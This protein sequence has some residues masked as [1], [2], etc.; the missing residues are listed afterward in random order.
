MNSKALF[1]GALLAAGVTA[2][3]QQFI[4]QDSSSD[5]AYTSFAYLVDIDSN[6]YNIAYA[7]ESLNTSL[8]GSYAEYS[9]TQSS[10]LLRIDAQ[11]DGTSPSG[12]AYGGGAF[13]QYFRV[14]EDSDLV[15]SWNLSGTDGFNTAFIVEDAS[16]AFLFNIFNIDGAITGSGSTTLRLSAGVD[17]QATLGFF[18]PT[19]TGSTFFPFLSST[20][21]QFI[22]TELIPAPATAGLMGLAGVM[23]TRRRR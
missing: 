12:Q 9:T 4:L 18:Q 21:V 10:N 2:N 16:G 11:Y 13:Q 7:P 19:I 15:V 17:Y 5:G 20:E 14:T 22:Q 23:V 8:S 6:A 1:G 3:A